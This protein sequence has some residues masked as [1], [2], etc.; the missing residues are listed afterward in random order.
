MKKQIM[1]T[2]P[3]TSHTKYV[4][5]GSTFVAIQGEQENGIM[6]IPQALHLGAT[7]IV[8]AQN[9]TIPHQIRHTIRA[10]G[11]RVKRVENTR[12]AIAQ[13][14]AQASDHAHK[15]LH[16][17]GI[18]GT[19]GKT[20]TSFILEHILAQ[21]GYKTALIST[22]YNKIN[23]QLF[24]ANLTTEQP[25]Y[26]HHFFHMC[27]NAQV[28]FVIMEV[29]AQ[30]LS[31]H[32]VEGILFDAVICTNFS[33]EHGEFYASMEEYFQAKCKLFAQR[34]PDAIALVNKDDDWSKKIVAQY[35]HHLSF[36]IENETADL[37]AKI[38]ESKHQLTCLIKGKQFYCPT[39]F[40]RFNAYN[41]LAAVGTAQ[42]LGISLETCAKS[43]LSFTGIP[44]RLEM[45]QLAKGTKCFIDY[46]HNPSSFDCVL[47]TL[48]TMTNDLI[49]IFGAGGNRDSKKRPIM[50]HIS[51]S[52]ADKIILTTDNPRTEDPDKII[53][54]IISGI[55]DKHMLKIIKEP[56]RKKAIQLACN[57]AKKSSVIAILGKGPD[58]YQIIGNNKMKFSEKEILADYQMEK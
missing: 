52:I 17:I 13:L 44:G 12:K 33:M 51:S 16:I 36:G 46:A 25:D 35:P 50:G 38:V 49:V 42:K 20:S 1:H 21:A 41:L 10:Y 58:E 23:N 5:Q 24:E 48:R 32:R 11:A 19:K 29:A 53:D 34:K 22:V 9:Q 37:I 3:V 45:F 55:D 56:N 14:S 47:S 57:V 28:D 54:D 30:A 2:F 15:K 43:I 8:V 6:Y 31:L 26:L 39:L 40:G 7:Q 4:G 18:T 27:L